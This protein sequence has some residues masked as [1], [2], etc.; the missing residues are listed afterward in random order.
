MAVMSAGVHW[1]DEPTSTD[2]HGR[3]IS[4][5]RKRLTCYVTAEM[6]TRLKCGRRDDA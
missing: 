4:V 5:G 1:N 2:I 3:S 6:C